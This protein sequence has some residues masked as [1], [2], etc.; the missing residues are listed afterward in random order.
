M[1]DKLWLDS[2]YMNAKI[3]CPILLLALA[4]IASAADNKGAGWSNHTGSD[5]LTR[6]AAAVEM[7]DNKVVSS[8]RADDAVECSNYVAGFLDSFQQG[9]KTT[10]CFPE[11]ANTGQMIRVFE[12]WLRDHPERLDQ[13]PSELLLSALR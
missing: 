9:N 12:K 10:F 8:Q 13:P 7:M 6:C 4:Q 11:H 3:I 5:Y 1:I 2:G